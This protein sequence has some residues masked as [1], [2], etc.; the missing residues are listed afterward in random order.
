M[1]TRPGRHDLIDSY[2]REVAECLPRKQRADVASELRQLLAEELDAKAVAAGR[3]AD[4]AMATELL[5][6][7]GR[8][9]EAAL[10][11]AAPVRL[12]H[13]VAHLDHSRRR[14]VPIA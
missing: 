4:A 2:V 13:I 3:P 7:F 11:Y 14:R 1:A 12:H 8:P 5:R 6:A 9:A 10:R